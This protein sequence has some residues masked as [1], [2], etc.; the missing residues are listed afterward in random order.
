MS[1]LFPPIKTGWWSFE[2]PEYRPHPQLSTYSLFSYEDLPPIQRLLDDEFCWLQA[3]PAKEHSLAEGCYP[4]GSEPD[5]TKLSHIMAQIEVQLPQS[6]LTFIETPQL[7]ERIRSCTDCFLEV[8]DLAVKTKGANEG[9]L[10]HFLSDSQWCVHWYLYVDSSGNHFVAASPNAYGF[11]FGETDED[12]D[13]LDQIGEIELEQEEICFCA[14][15]FNE[16]IYRFWLENEIWFAL[17]WDK[18]PLT[19]TEQAYIDH[20][21]NLQ[22]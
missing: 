7:H 15:S 14:P 17:A 5:L 4:D 18:R 10:I 2:L 9:F 21:R 1:A 22:V 11:T 13:A 19:T 6:F 8:A 12:M 16:F 3:L 20:Y